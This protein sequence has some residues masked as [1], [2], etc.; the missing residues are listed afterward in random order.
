MDEMQLVL[1]PFE[2][3]AEA[4]AELR[5]V[6]PYENIPAIANDIEA[7]RLLAVRHCDAGNRHDRDNVS[8]RYDPCRWWNWQPAR[9]NL[10]GELVELV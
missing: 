3:T 10:G 1:Q 9:D 8:L 5:R 7:E 4:P 2:A 6:V